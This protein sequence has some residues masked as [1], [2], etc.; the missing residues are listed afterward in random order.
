MRARRQTEAPLFRGSDKEE[1]GLTRAG[2]G[3]LQI[4]TGRV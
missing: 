4:N 2:E 1:F 3:D